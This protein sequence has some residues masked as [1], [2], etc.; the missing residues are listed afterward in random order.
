M[1]SEF[2]GQHGFDFSHQ[3]DYQNEVE[4]TAEELAA[5]L[6]TQSNVI[7]AAEHGHEEVEDVY[8]WLVAQTRQ[9]FKSGKATFPFSGFI[10]YLQK[11]S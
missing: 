2:A 11:A 4:F 8:D 5:Y 6:I 1:T 3:E 10:W 7:A 9:F